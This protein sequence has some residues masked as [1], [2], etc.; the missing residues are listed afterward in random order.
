MPN[1]NIYRFTFFL[2]LFCGGYAHSKE[3][4]AIIDSLDAPFNLAPYIEVLEDSEHQFTFEQ[5][6]SGTFKGDWKSNIEKDFFGKD[7]KIRYWFK[8]DIEYRN[9]VFQYHP[10]LYIPANPGLLYQLDIWLPEP[11]GTVRHVSTGSLTPFYQR[12]IETLRYAFN[13]PELQKFTVIGFVDNHQASMPARMPLYIVGNDTLQY[14]T[15]SVNGMLIGFYSILAAL[16]FYNACLYV[17]LKETVYGA[18]LV[19]LLTSAAVCSLTDATSAKWLWSDAPSFNIR[20]TI[21]NTISYFVFVWYSLNQ[22]TFAPRIR[23]IFH[24]LFWLGGLGFLHNILNDSLPVTNMVTQT[25]AA[26]VMPISVVA[27]ILAVRHHVPSV[28]YIFLA[29]IFTLSGVT[30]FMLL[31]M[32]V[33]PINELF[34]WS[35]HC[36]ILA[37]SLLLSLALAA[38]TRLAQQAAIQYLANY[39]TL[40]QESIEGLFRYSI[41][42]NSIECNQA[43]AKMCGYES[44]QSFYESTAKSNLFEVIGNNETVNLTKLLKENKE[45]KNYEVVIRKLG[46]KAA[47]WVSISARLINNDLAKVGVVEGLMIDIN[48]R[49]AREKAQMESEIAKNT[50]LA[51]MSHE[52]ITPMNGI[53]GYLELVQQ[54][55]LTQEAQ[56]YIEGIATSS[57]EMLMLVDRIL[58][59]TQLQVHGDNYIVEC[60]PFTFAELLGPIENNY[61]IRCQAKGITFNITQ[62]EILPARLWSDRKLIA[63]II[64][65]LLDNAVKFTH[66]GEI[67][68]SVS[69]LRN[70]NISE[71]DKN[72][73]YTIRFRI[74]D[75]GIGISREHRS[76]I[77][78]PFTQAD[79]SFHREFGGLGLGLAMCRKLIRLMNGDLLLLSEKGKGSQFDFI[80]TLKST[81]DRQDE[82]KD[83][84]ISFDKNRGD[85]SILI[86]EDNLTNQL[87]LKGIL[88]SLGYQS[89]VVENGLLAIEQ[90]MK[91]NFDLILMDCQMPIMDGFEATRKIRLAE[92][93]H[94][95]TH[96]IAVTAN[97]LQGDR[98]RCLEAG[99]DDYLKKP[100]KRKELGAKVSEWLAR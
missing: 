46:K 92:G 40:Y 79:G 88:N 44:L 15:Q 85:V 19:F 66:S 37:E 23:K 29:E 20:L 34:N 78:Q 86:A 74:E 12:D 98:E 51:T 100:I 93:Q 64:S 6:A 7:P 94:K 42:D 24:A 81:E 47:T 31:M 45:V 18:Y 67:K 26:V 32:G 54:C 55:Q 49:K 58:D 25:Y 73:S 22:L 21:I 17:S 72:Q 65:D 60:Q 1:L 76:Q 50:F 83:T 97:V 61:Q 57:N 4:T 99:M 16:F 75:S 39:Q 2:L 36:G 8:V 38:R 52:L 71:Y 68:L 95:H 69:A 27:I 3:S 35:M 9:R 41:D 87:V 11:G 33:V 14:F 13:L 48:E 43:F 5:I 91:N 59:F 84:E 30:S 77:F 89:C 90:A 28:G 63:R 53:E 70:K 82:A 62:D 56:N 10:K 96:I 80:L